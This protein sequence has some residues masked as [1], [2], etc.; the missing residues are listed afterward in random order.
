MGS[1]YLMITMTKS[2]MLFRS[3]KYDHVRAISFKVISTTNMMVKMMLLICNI[4][5]NSLGCRR[6]AESKTGQKGR[7]I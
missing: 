6:K 5:V 2:K 7:E 3:L 1:Y 4:R